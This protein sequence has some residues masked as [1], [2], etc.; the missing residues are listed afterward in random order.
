MFAL[1]V[2]VILPSKPRHVMKGK[3]KY[4][5]ITYDEKDMNFRI[6]IREEFFEIVSTLF[7]AD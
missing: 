3:L 6:H 7:G 2:I 5:S 1:Y 4:I